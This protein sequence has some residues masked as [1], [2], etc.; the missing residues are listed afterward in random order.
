MRKVWVDSPLKGCG[1]ESTVCVCVWECEHHCGEQ[2][3]R[4]TADDQIFL[5]L[6]PYLSEEILPL[7]LNKNKWGTISQCLT[8]ATPLKN[9]WTHL[10]VK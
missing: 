6:V 4:D 5:Q 1:C 9:V 3:V 7:S 8:W 2:K 10:C